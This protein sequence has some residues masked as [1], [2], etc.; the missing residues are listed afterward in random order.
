MT[1]L[2]VRCP[3]EKAAV[4]ALRNMCS[5]V[6]GTSA[7]EEQP[8]KD[9]CAALAAYDQPAAPQAEP[10]RIVEMRLCEVPYLVLKPQTY[11]LTVDPGCWRCVEA[12]KA[13][14]GEATAPAPA[15]CQVH[16]FVECPNPNGNCGL[17]D[18]CH[19]CY[20]D[21]AYHEHAHVAAPTHSETPAP[22]VLCPTCGVSVAWF[23]A[24][25][26]AWVCLSCKATGTYGE[27]SRP[28]PTETPERGK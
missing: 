20:R 18:L 7:V 11:R 5:L 26:G 4:E 2:V 13:S 1:P 25:P 14:R 19:A 21:R 8:Y 27:P 12:E 10:E 23:T 16:K 17:K 22:A 15:S 3:R 6:A 9:A 28:T 24:T